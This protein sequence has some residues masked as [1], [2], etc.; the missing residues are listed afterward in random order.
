MACAVP[1]RPPGGDRSYR[2][3]VI[4]RLHYDEQR[5]RDA[6]RCLEAMRRRLESGWQVSG[7][8]LLGRGQFSVLFRFETPVEGTPGDVP[9][10]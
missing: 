8:N 7:V 6:E 9:C 10:A 5:Y 1:R 4:R 3:D 2:R